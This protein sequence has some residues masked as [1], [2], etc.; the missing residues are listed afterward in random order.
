MGTGCCVNKCAAQVTTDS[1][2]S[3]ILRKRGEHVHDALSDRDKEVVVVSAACKRAAT[4]ALDSRPRKIIRREIRNCDH[5]LKP[6]TKRIAQTMYRAK[7]KLL[8]TL[9]KSGKE[10]I[11]QFREDITVETSRNELF[12]FPIESSGVLIF[13][14]ETNLRLLAECD[15]ILA[16]GTFDYAPD[17]FA[18]MYTI[19]GN[20]MGHNVR[21]AYCCLPNK[22]GDTYVAM[23]E[24]LKN[25]VR[26][27][28]GVEL[29]PARILADFEDAPLAAF[30]KCFP[31]CEI[32]ACKFHFSQNLMKR[33]RACKS[34]LAAYRKPESEIGQWLRAMNALPNLSPSEVPDAFVDLLSCAPA[35]TGVL[36][37]FSDYVLSTYIETKRFPPSLWARAPV[38]DDPTT[39]N[40]AESFHS[41]YNQDHTSA[42]PNIHV[43]LQ[44]LLDQQEET[45][46][47]ERTIRAAKERAK[48]DREKDTN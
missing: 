26:E 15:T 36:H 43:T 35:T 18:Q 42:H 2:L 29:K 6:D 22:K 14:C 39:T 17:Q 11:D 12:S 41:H 25:L 48:K 7:R 24:A 10:V 28:V 31:D 32:R 16:D 37:I 9:P 8:P 46:L 3:R 1:A 20:K 47:L 40:A 38:L 23:L 45:Y 33:I 4:E 44:A 30:R 21:L 27:K 5:I 13:T 34:M 19:H